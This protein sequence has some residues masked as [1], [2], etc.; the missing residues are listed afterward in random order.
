MDENTALYEE[1]VRGLFDSGSDEIVSNGKPEHAIVIFKL[2]L[3]RAK[4]RVLIF[5][6]DLNDA[7][8]GDDRLLAL[9]KDAVS[10]GVSIQVI[11]QNKDVRPS[12]FLDWVV[13]QSK[14]SNQ[15]LYGNCSEGQFG[16]FPAN[17]AVMDSRAFRFESDRNKIAALA[18][19]NKPETANHLAGIF[20]G[21]KAS[22]GHSVKH[23]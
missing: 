21:I 9:A 5:C 11:A 15:V 10:R 22:L 1:L 7:V 13:E 20:E 16:S 14:A 12:R 23:A 6:R 18:S 19:M 4:S 3:E 2:F 17:F 8:F